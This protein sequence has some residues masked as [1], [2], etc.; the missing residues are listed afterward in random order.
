MGWDLSFVE[1][2]DLFC[3]ECVAERIYLYFSARRRK[4]LSSPFLPLSATVAKG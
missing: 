1:D 4:G 2:G 3:C